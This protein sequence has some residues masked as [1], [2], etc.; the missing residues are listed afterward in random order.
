MAR[1]GLSKFLEFIGLVD[2]EPERPTTV[3]RPEGRRTRS[4]AAARKTPGPS[5]RSLVTA[6]ATRPRGR[7][8][9]APMR[10]ALLPGS[11]TATAAATRRSRGLP[12]GPPRREN[13]APAALS[14]IRPDRRPGRIIPPDRRSRP[15]P[16]RPTG[17]IPSGMNSSALSSRS[18]PE[19]TSSPCRTIPGIRPS[20]TIS[21]RWR[22]AAT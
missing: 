19:A 5:G 20:S 8:A 15:A 12:I 9:R 7:T 6:R 22:S 18:S 21:T 4:R 10:R 16:P 13:T 14:P 3:S 2:D 1:G 17:A 11:M